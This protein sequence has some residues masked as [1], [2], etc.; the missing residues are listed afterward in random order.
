VSAAGADH[1][2][3]ASDLEAAAQLVL[4]A[5]AYVPSHLSEMR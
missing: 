5:V 4:A 2:P 1:A 3:A